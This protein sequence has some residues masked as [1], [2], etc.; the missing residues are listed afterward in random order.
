MFADREFTVITICVTISD[1]GQ[2]DDGS[3]L[4]CIMKTM[5]NLPHE[6]LILIFSFLNHRDLVSIGSL[7]KKLKMVSQDVTLWKTGRELRRQSWRI[8]LMQVTSGV[9]RPFL[10]TAR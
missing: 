8:L 4:A 1:T 7:C 9:T 3:I 6:I 10:P 2:E 5:E